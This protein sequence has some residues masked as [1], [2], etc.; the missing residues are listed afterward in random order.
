ML[1]LTCGGGGSLD[2]Q[3]TSLYTT[4]HRYIDTYKWTSISGGSLDSQS[5]SL[6]TLQLNIQSCIG[7]EWNR[8]MY[9]QSN[10]LTDWPTNQKCFFIQCF[11]AVSWVRVLILKDFQAIKTSPSKLLATAVNVRQVRKCSPKQT[12]SGH[13]QV[14]PAKRGFSGT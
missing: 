2:S 10:R 14:W 7:K 8:K 6:Y 5:T 9:W 1:K 13:E 11:D 4:L 3:S 12:C